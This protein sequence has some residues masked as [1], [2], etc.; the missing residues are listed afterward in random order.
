MEGFALSCVLACDV[1]LLLLILEPSGPIDAYLLIAAAE[2]WLGR[3]EPLLG[4]E[5]LHSSSVIFVDWVGTAA[6]TGTGLAAYSLSELVDNAA[7]TFLMFAST[8]TEDA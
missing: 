8:P 1:L 4:T 2:D 5:S 3:K 6:A 7:S